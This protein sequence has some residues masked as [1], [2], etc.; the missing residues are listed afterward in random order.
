MHCHIA[1]ILV[2]QRQQRDYKTEHQIWDGKPKCKHVWGDMLPGNNRGGSGTGNNRRKR[3][4]RDWDPTG[5]ESP[6]GRIYGRDTAK[7]CFCL[8]CGCW[9]GELGQEP[10]VELFVRHTVQVFGELYRVLKPSGV[11]FLNIGDTRSSGAKGPNSLPNGQ[12]TYR[13]GNGDTRG[14]VKEKYLALIPER[15]LIALDDAGWIIRSKIVWEK[16]CL[17]GGT[18]LYVRTQKGDMPMMVRDLRRLK[19]ETVKLWNG[20]KWTQLVGMWQTG[21]KSDEIELVLRSGERI[22]CTPNHRW[23]TSRGLLETHE[24]QV[25]D[26][27]TMTALPEPELPRDCVLDLDAAWLAGLYIAEGSRSGSTLSFAGH[28]REK[29]RW[30]RVQQIARKFGGSATLTEAGNDQTIRVYGRLLLAIIEEL[31]T[32]RTSKDKGIAPV[33]WRYSNAFINA[34]MEGYLSGDGHWETKTKRWRIGF[35][36]NYNLERDMRVACSR[37]GWHLILNKTSTVAFGK[38]FQTFRGEIRTSRSGHWS[39]KSPLE[40]VAIQKARCREVYDLSVEDEPHVLAL[41]SGV[42]S[43]NSAMPESAGDRPTESWEPIYMLVKNPKYWSDFSAIREACRPNTHARLAQNVADQIGSTRAN[44]NS[45]P[46]RPMKAVGRCVE[47]GQGIRNNESFASAI[48]LPLDWKP[49]ESPRLELDEPA[50][51]DTYKGSLPGRKDG[52]G[53]DR[54]SKKD[55]VLKMDD[56]PDRRKVGFNQ[57]WDAKEDAGEIGATRNVRNVWRFS[58]PG[59]KFAHYSAFP[60][61]LP[62]R[63]ILCSTKEGDTVLDP[64]VGTGTTMAVA[65]E[66]GRNAIGIDID[67]ANAEFVNKRLSG[68]NPAL[69]FNE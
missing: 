68:A 61:E 6:V 4:G 14:K 41:A 27:L 8:K 45:R 26:H 13:T 66:L 7:G 12:L 69:R 22:S 64:F 49:D 20:E 56:S 47:A 10:T 33:V 51:P 16:P 30:S 28:S 40:I 11:L 2:T 65:V 37:L 52:P 15:L 19:P 39:Q 34:L 50:L 18:W 31:T 43:H 53:Q 24:L 9:K 32:G 1:S 55:R 35:T 46:D 23:P 62:R 60:P 57:R 3:I 38:R 29:D 67:P 42:L 21:R 48:A 36:R 25:G 59:T 5:G 63:C 44:G 54:R 58:N 17:S